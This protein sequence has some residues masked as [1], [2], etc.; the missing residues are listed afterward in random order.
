MFAGIDLIKNSRSTECDKGYTVHIQRKQKT[1]YDKKARQSFDDTNSFQKFK[2]KALQIF[3]YCST[4]H[5]LWRCRTFGKDYK[6]M[7]MQQVLWE[8]EQKQQQIDT[9]R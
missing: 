8:A 1:R 5:E 6:N 2:N 4:T 3:K 7:W 9:K